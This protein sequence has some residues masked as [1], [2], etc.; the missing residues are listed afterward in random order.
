MSSSIKPAAPRGEI[1]DAPAATRMPVN[2][3]ELG[4]L[5]IWL[6]TRIYMYLEHVSRES[7]IV[8]DVNYYF[9]GA[10]D[11]LEGKTAL[12][13][14]PAPVAW[15]LAGLRLLSG[16]DA[17]RYVAIFVCTMAALDLLVSGL[18]W[19][20]YSKIA[21]LYWMVFLLFVG[22]LT[23]YRIDLLAAVPFLLALLWFGSVSWPIDL[24]NEQRLVRD[25]HPFA[26]GGAVAFGAAMK[27]WPALLIFPML[28]RSQRA[29]QRG[30]GFV[31]VG[32]L[33]GLSSLLIAG[34]ERSVSPMTWQSDR[35]LHVESV[36]ATGPMWRRTF[37][38][39]ADQY[40]IEFS[41][42]NAFEIFGPNCARLA[43]AADLT[44]YFVVAMALI[45]CWLIAFGGV[46]LPGRQSATAVAKQ[47]SDEQW[48]ATV[49]AVVALMLATIAAN[50]TFSPQYLIWLAGPL[51]VLVTLRGNTMQR[52]GQLLVGGMGLL[53]AALTRWIFP[54]HYGQIIGAPDQ[55]GTKVLVLRNVLVIIAV[56]G[57]LILAFAQAWRL[58]AQS[59]DDRDEP[60]AE[61]GAITE[62]GT[63]SEQTGP[64]ARKAKQTRSRRA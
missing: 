36:W 50:K 26:S 57:S 60:A 14:Y 35:G 56:V 40:Q 63:S 5:P 15:L 38:P 10:S 7:H 54:L 37:G 30:R 47:D 6:L 29:K 51:A 18:L 55:T 11:L 58:G 53:I 48:R 32:G 23:W 12:V 20:R 61:S 21:S 13:E 28:G 25:G 27:L 19:M 52:V 33:L 2:L 31:I 8:G 16:D 62:S 39:H 22:S 4:W 64:P 34:W 43:Y 49:L 3:A 41:D 59:A 24:R 44:M 46:G 1:S 9:M 17:G 45:F 42:F